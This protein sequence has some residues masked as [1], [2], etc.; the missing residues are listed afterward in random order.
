MILMV[1]VRTLTS[2]QKVITVP[3]E[4]NVGIRLALTDVS[5]KQV[6]SEMELSAIMANVLMKLFVKKTN[7]VSAQL[8]SNVNVKKAFIGIHTIAHVR[9][10]MSVVPICMLVP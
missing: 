4:P 9:I 1:N 10:R 6:I 2:A 7:S 8:V 3:K 5:V